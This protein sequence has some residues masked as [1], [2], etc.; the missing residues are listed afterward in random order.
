M[1]GLVILLLMIVG[2]ASL[3]KLSARLLKGSIISWKNCF[4]FSA[5]FVALAMASRIII[6]KTNVTIPIAVAL[7]NGFILQVALS[8]WFFQNRGTDSTGNALG[9]RGGMKLTAT[10]Y[11]IIGSIAIALFGLLYFLQD[12]MSH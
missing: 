8:G 3:I 9:W 11:G 12:S 7:I 5:I 2:Y 6:M 1:M 10:A 4:I